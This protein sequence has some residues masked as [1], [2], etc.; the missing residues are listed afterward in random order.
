MNVIIQVIVSMSETDHACL[1]DDSP[2][3]DPL[4]NSL[5][6]MIQLERIPTRLLVIPGHAAR[7]GTASEADGSEQVTRLTTCCYHSSIT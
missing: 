1:P 5:I 6:Q 7:H 4:L 3:N 2:V